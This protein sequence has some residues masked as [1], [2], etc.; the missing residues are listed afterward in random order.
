M[1]MQ[2]VHSAWAAV[3][4]TEGDALGMRVPF[5]VSI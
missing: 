1:G 2:S 4:V 5:W 3:Y